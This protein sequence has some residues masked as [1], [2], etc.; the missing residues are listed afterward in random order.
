[1]ITI[2]L[3]LQCFSVYWGAD[4]VKPAQF[5]K[6]PK[7]MVLVVGETARAE[8]FSLKGY[9]KNIR[10]CPHLALHQINKQAKNNMDL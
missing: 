9:A 3:C 7:L 2:N 4:V 1:M 8:S 5:S 6:P 10:A